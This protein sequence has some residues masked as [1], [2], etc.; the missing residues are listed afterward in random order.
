V[1][2]LPAGAAVAAAVA[3]GTGGRRRTV[4]LIAAAPVLALAILVALDLILGGGAH[5]TSSVLRAGGASGVAD[6]AQRRIELSVK[7]FGRAATSP[8]LYITALAMVVAVVYRRRLAELFGNHLAFAGLCGAA[9]AT[10]LGTVANDS[11]AVLLMIGTGFLL[12]CGI[13]LISVDSER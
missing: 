13:F 9:A 12:A 7:S 2:V 8:Y 11:G 10:L 1:I 4:L 6:V 3:A 5:L